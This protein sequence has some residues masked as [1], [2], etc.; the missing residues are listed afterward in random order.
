MKKEL[1]LALIIIGIVHFSL[2][3]VEPVICFVARDNYL[4]RGELRLFINLVLIGVG[5][6]FYKEKSKC[7]HG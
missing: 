2:L 1:L 5:Y 7:L 6:F 4:E 3:V